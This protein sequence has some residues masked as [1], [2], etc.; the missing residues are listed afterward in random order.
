VDAVEGIRGGAQA[1]RLDVIHSQLAGLQGHA[2][3][4]PGKLFGSLLGAADELRHARSNHSNF[5]HTH[6]R[7]SFFFPL[8]LI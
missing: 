3:G 2:A 1:N 7:F 8:R 6:I 4:L 5:S